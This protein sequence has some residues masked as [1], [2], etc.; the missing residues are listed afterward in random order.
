MKRTVFIVSALLMFCGFTQAQNKSSKDTSIKKV[1]VSICNCLEKNHV[2]KANTEEEMQQVFL[3]CIF[4]SASSVI[5]DVLTSGDGDAK[6]N[7]EEFGQKI[8]L[9]LMNSGCQPFIQM[10]VKLAKGNLGADDDADAKPALKSVDGIITKVEEKD[11]LYI[12]VKQSTGREMILIYMDY[13]DG[14]DGWIKDAAAK[15]TNKT[16]SV[17]Y[18]ESEIYQPKI[19]DFANLKVLRKLAITK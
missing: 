12:T 2:E 18:E 14:S 13:V 15:L 3:Q 6:Q 19:K 17:S 9:E 16:V 10:S 11:F 1:A 4:D 8:A 7:G 5:G